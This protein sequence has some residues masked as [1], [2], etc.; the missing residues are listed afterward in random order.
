[1]VQVREDNG[2]SSDQGGKL[3]R[4]T[5]KWILSLERQKKSSGD[6]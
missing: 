3:Y 2:L 6:F 4:R 1:M 5:G